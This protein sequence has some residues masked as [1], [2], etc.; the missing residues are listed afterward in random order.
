MEIWYTPAR[1]V[2]KKVQQRSE[3]LPLQSPC[4]EDA[5]KR[6]GAC[7]LPQ[8]IFSVLDHW[9]FENL[10]WVR[11]SGQV[12]HALTRVDLDGAVIAST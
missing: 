8:K 1:M 11:L 10:A 5:D 3:I 9:V 6:I 4:I 12:F 7:H 2:V